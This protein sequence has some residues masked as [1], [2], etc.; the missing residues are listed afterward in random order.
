VKLA[1]FNIV[2]WLPCGKKYIEKEQEKAISGFKKKIL[3][4]RK[5]QVYKLP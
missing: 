3:S 5:N 2:L 4:H 1:L